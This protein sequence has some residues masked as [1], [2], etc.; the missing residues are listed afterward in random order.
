MQRSIATVSLSGTLPEKL[1]AIAAAGFDGV[2]I[3][4]NDLLYYDG[5]PRHVRQICADLGIAITLFQPFRDFEGCRRDRLPR[6]LDRAER[7]FDLMQ[8]LGTDLVLVCSNSAADSLGDEHIL[9]DDLAMLAE[10]AGARQ[11]RVGYEALAWGRHVNTWQ[12][13]WNLVKQV[14][15]PALGVLLDSFHT[16]S[17]KGDPSAIA[18]I[19]GDKI[20]FVQMAD[21]PILAMDVME[22]SRHFRC[23][24]GQ[25]EF[26]LPG[27][28]APILKTGYTGPLSLEI[29]NDGFRAAPPRSNAADGLRSLLYLEEK[30]R[31]LLEQQNEPIAKDLLFSP[32]P[33]S[34][35][36]GVEFLEFA[37]DDAQ[38]ARLAGWLSNLGFARLGQHRSKAVSLMGQG[39]IKIVLNAE[40]YS[41][42]HSFF[43][44]HGPS[45]CATALRVENGSAALERA[46]AF[47]GQPYRGLVGPNE[48]EV[49][50]VRAPDGSLIY[51][52]E[53]A[54]PGESIYDIDFMVN[55]NAQAGGGLQRIDHMAM[56]LPADSLDSWVLF[57]KSLL[58]F[59]ADDEVVLPDP[60][61]LVKSRAL[62]SRCSTVRLPL[63]ISENR[64]TAISHALSSYRGS[65]VHHI[66]FAC[67][68]I[69]AEVSRAKEAGLKLLDIPL[70]YYDDL[71]ARFD[72]DDEFLSELAYYNVLYDRDAQGGELFHVYT[73]PFDDRFFFEI[74]QRKNGYVGYGAANVAV[75]L[76]AMAKTR[77]GAARQARL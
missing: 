69:F 72:F 63:N 58:D 11:L 12:Q 39:D 62:R 61:G 33:A 16:L 24:P 1:E 48:R 15:H 26:D 75:R 14:D 29:F 50:S 7:K 5:S 23:F 54:V 46:Q 37:V 77:S 35:Y 6:N 49:P 27:F 74:L 44:A 56:A 51:L 38:G 10:R 65:G 13:V 66:A 34:T 17:L 67:E 64:N 30:T 20:F 40:P 68:D 28:L 9:R 25:G 45:L 70:N 52:V 22:W 47:K 3:F 71:A 19:P 57:Y 76:A 59:E 73:E 53:P 36:N 8:E 18:Q 41:F 2:E 4:E 43:E 42:A 60:Y 21:A 31:L 32:P 55:P